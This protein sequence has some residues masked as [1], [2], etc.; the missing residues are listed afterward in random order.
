[1]RL[2]FAYVLPQGDPDHLVHQVPKEKLRR[3]S[4]LSRVRL[5]TEGLLVSM[6]RE[7]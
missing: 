2:T 1:M 3:V 6:A 5:E 7:V 4:F